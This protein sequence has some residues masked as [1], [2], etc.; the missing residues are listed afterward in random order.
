MD[1]F[2]T[3][4]QQS[5]VSEDRSY[6]TFDNE[7]CVTSVWISSVEVMA[8]WL[9]DHTGDFTALCRLLGWCGRRSNTVLISSW[10]RQHSVSFILLKLGISNKRA[11]IPTVYDECSLKFDSRPNFFIPSCKQH[12]YQTNDQV[13]INWKEGENGNNKFQKEALDSA[14]QLSPV[15]LARLMEKSKRCN[16]KLLRR[17]EVERLE[18]VVFIPLIT[19]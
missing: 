7:L 3:S 9:S 17:N 5:S 8:A 11:H 14:D 10:K 13:L 19:L 6:L 4:L 15:Y 1:H 12:S 18:R 2:S 16:S